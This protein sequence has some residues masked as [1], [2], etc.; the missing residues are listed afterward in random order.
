MWAIRRA[1]ETLDALHRAR[2]NGQRPHGV[3]LLEPMPGNARWIERE[4]RWGF[5][6]I[7]LPLAEGYELRGLW[8]ITVFL[9]GSARTSPWVLEIGPR[10]RA[11]HPVALYIRWPSR[12]PGLLFETEPVPLERPPAEVNAPEPPPLPRGDTRSV[13][14]IAEQIDDR[15]WRAQWKALDGGPAYESLGDRWKRVVGDTDDEKPWWEIAE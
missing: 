12:R 2:Q 8:G 11:V 4:A 13:A 3:V 9:A 5:L 15:E 10:I 1:R 14:Q 6:P 7:E